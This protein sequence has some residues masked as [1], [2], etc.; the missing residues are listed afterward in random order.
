MTSM[1]F[2]EASFSSWGHSRYAGRGSSRS[3]ER[4]NLGGGRVL[5]TSRDHGFGAG[6][7]DSKHHATVGGGDNGGGS[8][9]TFGAG[10]GSRTKKRKQKPNAFSVF[11]F[12]QWHRSG[13]QGRPDSIFTQ[14]ISDKWEAMDI[15]SRQP[16]KDRA[17]VQKCVVLS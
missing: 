12:D 3:G 6:R 4:G 9:G 14:E 16:Y 11:L 8:H 1:S 15:E 5:G 10:T 17:G 2:D 13:R 7:H